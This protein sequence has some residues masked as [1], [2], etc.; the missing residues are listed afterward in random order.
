MSKKNKKA[1]SQKLNRS[2]DFTPEPKVLQD[3]DAYCRARKCSRSYAV[4]LAVKR[5]LR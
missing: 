4:R 2:I 5:M 3:L 1:R